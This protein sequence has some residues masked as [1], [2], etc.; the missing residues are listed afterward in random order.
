MGR[1]ARNSGKE[2]TRTDVQRLKQMARAGRTTPAIARELGRSIAAV[3][4]KASELGVS[5]M[6]RD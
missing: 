1:K 5:L 3:Y 2:W 4:T 6:P